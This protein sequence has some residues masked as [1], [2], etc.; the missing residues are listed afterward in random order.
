MKN[1]VKF[2]G[3]W[4]GGVASFTYFLPKLLAGV[5]IPDAAKATIAIVFMCFWSVMSLAVA[6]KR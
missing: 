1:C 3:L 2:F 5:T 4:L 6:L